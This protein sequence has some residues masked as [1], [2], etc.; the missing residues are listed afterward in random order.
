M[1]LKQVIIGNK[2]VGE[3]AP[4]FI[5]AEIASAHEGS[6]KNAKE[7]LKAAIDSGADAVKFQV[8]KADELLT[9]NHP[10]YESFK[11]IEF[12][13]NEWGRIFQYGNKL[14]AT[15]LADVFDKESADLVERYVSAYKIHSTNVSDPCLLL[16]VA[17][18]R[19]PMLLST[20]GCTI[21]EI[22][23]AVKIIKPINKSI[24]LMHGYQGFPTKLEDINL[25][26]LKTLKK[27]FKLPVG[28]SDHVDA[29]SDMSVTLPLVALAFD[30]SVIEKHITLDRNLKGRD[31]CS[32]L[33]PDE[34]RTLVDKIRELETALGTGLPRLSKEELNYREKMKKYIVAKVDIPKGTKITEDMLIF[35]RTV[36]P[37]IPP[38]KIGKIVG[39]TAKSNI[40]K[41]KNIT[42]SKLK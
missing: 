14:K 13:E 12:N 26:F 29:E 11:K 38:I 25:S 24:I 15:L 42:E 27:L 39:K 4:V 17:K 3:D 7:L 33:N 40:K 6:L 5:I 32:A 41:D 21:D 16:H 37:G 36:K 22:R 23:T 2:K 28:L 20:A 19:K 1:K 34:F 9:K 31:Y 35:K 10:R 30:A 18:K 8:F